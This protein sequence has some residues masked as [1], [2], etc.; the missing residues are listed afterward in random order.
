[1]PDQVMRTKEKICTD[2][3]LRY[4]EQMYLKKEDRDTDCV[5]GTYMRIY[6]ENFKMMI[7]RREISFKKKLMYYTFYI[8]P[9]IGV[10]MGKIFTLRK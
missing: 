3:I 5:N 4:C 8:M 10:I 1:M 6:R 7:K 2:M 9:S